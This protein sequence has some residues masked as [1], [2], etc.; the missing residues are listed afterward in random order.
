MIAETVD[1]NSMTA[2]TIWELTK[3]L[4]ADLQWLVRQLGN[5]H[6]R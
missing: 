2:Y 1:P 5:P 3:K 4:P 6:E